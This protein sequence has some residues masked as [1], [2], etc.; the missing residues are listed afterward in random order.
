MTENWPK[1]QDMHKKWPRID[2][3]MAENW[4]RNGREL[5]E[6]WPRNWYWK[7]VWA[8]FDLVFFR[9]FSVFQTIEGLIIKQKFIDFSRGTIGKNDPKQKSWLLLY[10]I[11]CIHRSICC[12]KSVSSLPS[13]LLIY[14]GAIRRVC[15]FIETKMI[16]CQV[17]NCTVKALEMH[18]QMHP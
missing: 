14:D 3:E 7:C 1:K 4:P 8:V 16:L 12:R 13:S 11:A 18:R 15:I 17:T 9:Y 10:G 2:W 6:K 5:S